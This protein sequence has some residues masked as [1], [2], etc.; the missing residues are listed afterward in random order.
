MYHGGLCWS[1]RVGMKFPEVAVLSKH[2]EDAQIS[3]L[4]YKYSLYFVGILIVFA[5]PKVHRGGGGKLN[6]MIC[7]AAVILTVCPHLS[8]CTHHFEWVVSWSHDL[9]GFWVVCVVLR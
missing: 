3:R 5:C 1:K 8:E 7:G 6:T 9:L 2:S 4:Q